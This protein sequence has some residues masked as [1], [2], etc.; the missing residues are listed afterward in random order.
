MTPQIDLRLPTNEPFGS[1]NDNQSNTKSEESFSNQHDHTSDEQAIQPD[2]KSYHD[3]E[4]GKLNRNHKFCSFFHNLIC[5]QTLTRLDNVL[6]SYL[7]KVQATRT[8]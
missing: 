4:F 5:C 8:S 6:K 1:D 7:E 2:T 3:L